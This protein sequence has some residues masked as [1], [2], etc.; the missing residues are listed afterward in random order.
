MMKRM[1]YVGYAISETEVPKASGVS[2]AGNKMQLN[3]LRELSK[4]ED[5]EI[6]PIT[7]YPSAAFPID[8]NL[9]Y[10][11]Q[12]MN[13]NLWNGQHA[14]RLGFLNVPIVKQI[15][16]MWGVYC[17]IQKQLKNSS[18]VQIFS[19]NMYPQV[20]TPLRW[21]NRKYDVDVTAILA[22]L[23]ID[24]KKNRRGLS[25]V[26][27][28][29]FNSETKRN[30][31]S[32]DRAIVL[33]RNAAD[34][35]L[36]NQEYIVVEGGIHAEESEKESLHIKDYSGRKRIIIYSGALVEYNGIQNLIEA[37]KL[38]HEDA[39]LRLYGDGPLKSYV[40]REA[41]RN[42]NIEYMGKVSNE[43]MIMI[44]KEAYLLINPRPID[45]PISRVTFPSK[46]FEYLMSGTVVLT[47]KMSGFTDEYLDKMIFMDD[48]AQGIARKIDESMQIPCDK[49]NE[50]ANR[51][52]QFVTKEKNWELQGKKI[53]EFLMQDG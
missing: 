24:I 9:I 39:I 27:M 20:G 45:D 14:L 42:S 29:I 25:R 35:Y 22:D 23:P 44:L 17:E 38:I 8:S 37:M 47:T 49:M 6:Y 34:Q 52:Y 12:Y 51:A 30:I 15:C 53:H 16:Q 32:L 48:D 10:K 1:I 46:I 11:K 28:S 43:E 33:N 3:V 4:Y 5:L 41:E 2:I 13:L 18:N 19:F 40:E 36:E 21:L 50:M 31:K 26:L 7:I